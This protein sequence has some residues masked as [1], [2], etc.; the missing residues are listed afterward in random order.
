M[1]RKCQIFIYTLKCIYLS[2]STFYT[3]NFTIQPNRFYR[4]VGRLKAKITEPKKNVNKSVDELEAL[5]KTIQKTVIKA[6]CSICNKEFNFH[7]FNDDT[8]TFSEATIKGITA[9]CPKCK[10]KNQRQKKQINN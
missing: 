4:E 10:E 5:N 1:I 3:N 9:T 2:H 8:E 7:I 6:R